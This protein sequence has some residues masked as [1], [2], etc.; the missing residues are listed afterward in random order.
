MA[1]RVRKPPNRFG[2]VVQ[3]LS[4]HSEN[5]DTFGDDSF[6][7]ESYTPNKDSQRTGKYIF[8]QSNGSNDDL[9]CFDEEFEKVRF[10]SANNA[11]RME[12]SQGVEPLYV[13][14]SGVN[15]TGRQLTD[16]ATGKPPL[17]SD[18]SIVDNTPVGGISHNILSSDKFNTEFQLECLRQF[19]KL[20]DSAAQILVR[21]TAIEQS[22][23]RDGNLIT[24]NTSL[25]MKPAPFD[26]FHSFVELNKLP[27]KTVDDFKSFEL[28]L[29]DET[30][31]N[32][33]I[34]FI[35]IN[36]SEQYF[37]R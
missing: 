29:N 37:L 18:E 7:D 23:M 15:S 8:S 13:I 11:S 1:T 20:N 17:Q 2:E 12:R 30:M 6:A 19:K 25:E 35:D 4:E 22:L 34:I 36:F 32:A 27:L 21:I 3:N 9:P 31:E 10:E 14:E 28:S 33:V 5:D 26:A 24:I 16:N